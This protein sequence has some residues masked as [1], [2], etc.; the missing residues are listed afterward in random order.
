MAVISAKMVIKARKHYECDACDRTIVPGESYIYLYGSA[1][2]RERP[3][4]LR[5]C[6]ACAC[7]SD[8]RPNNKHGKALRSHVTSKASSKSLFLYFW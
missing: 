3:Y 6:I 2:S 4:P 8:Y 7:E 5:E 1:D